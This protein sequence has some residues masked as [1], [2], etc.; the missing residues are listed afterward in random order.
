MRALQAR[1]D[2][3]LLTAGPYFFPD[4]N[5][6][7]EADEQLAIDTG[8]IQPNGIRWVGRPKIVTG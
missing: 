8:Q 3:V 5:G 4:L 2:T 7:T 1:F 6:V